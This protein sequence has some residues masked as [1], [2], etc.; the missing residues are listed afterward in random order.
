MCLNGFLSQCRLLDSV[1]LSWA[2][3]IQ[4]FKAMASF[5]LKFILKVLMLLVFPQ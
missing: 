1:K 5:L 3:V 4:E 2:S